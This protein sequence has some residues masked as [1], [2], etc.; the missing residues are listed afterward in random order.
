[1][2]NGQV[3]IMRSYIIS[4][5]ALLK[6]ITG[7]STIIKKEEIQPFMMNE[8]RLKQI[9]DAEEEAQTLYETAVKNTNL[10]PEQAERE[11][12]TLLQETRQRAQIESDRLTEEIIN[13]DIINE[14][15][16]Q[17]ASRTAQ[18]DSLAEV[19]LPKAIDYVVRT[20]LGIKA[21]E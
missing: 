5:S 13:P 11:V 18:R 17:Y 21:T 10:L 12:E 4:A 8:E 1:M 6:N 16:N 3:G 9:L 14:I 7:K 19:N 20:L 2:M 15:V